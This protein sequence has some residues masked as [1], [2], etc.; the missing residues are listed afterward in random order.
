[1]KNSHNRAWRLNVR[2]FGDDEIAQLA[3]KAL[4]QLV[5]AKHVFRSL[6]WIGR[7]ASKQGLSHEVKAKPQSG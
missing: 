6:N 3:L 4:L 5:L 1:L 7:C 2:L